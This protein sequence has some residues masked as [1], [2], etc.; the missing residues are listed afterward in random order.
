MTQEVS[1]F[2]PDDDKAFITLVQEQLKKGAAQVRGITA[3]EYVDMARNRWNSFRAD[4][5]YAMKLLFDPLVQ[6]EYCEGCR[7]EF[8]CLLVARIDHNGELMDAPP[9]YKPP[10][11]KG[12]KLSHI[13]AGSPSSGCTPK[14]S[15]P[16]LYLVAY[17]DIL[18]FESLLTRVGLP[19]L[20]RLYNKLLQTALAP[21]SEAHPW[22]KARSIVKGVIVPALMWVPIQTAY[23]S[24]SIL[25]WVHYNPGH[26][27]DFLLR[28]S[29]VFCEALEMGLPMRGAISFGEAIF[30]KASNTFLG[31]PLVEAARIEKEQDWVGVTIGA[32]FKDE[33]H[34]IPVPPEMVSVYR[35]PMKTNKEELL[36]GLVLDWPRVWRELKTGSA[37]KCLNALCSPELPEFIKKRYHA[38]ASFYEYSEKHQDWFFPKGAIKMKA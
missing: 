6:P 32:S 26:V 36:S 38:S 33:K 21:N 12:V 5:V 29:K 22:S 35:P 34:K 16:A 31:S 27:G 20:H 4:A 37:L 11:Y 23:F 17:I 18:G 2:K 24:D 14:P 7:D 15:E 25:L 1:P 13:V 9:G 30:D 19:E 10:E 8:Y 3:L 28:I